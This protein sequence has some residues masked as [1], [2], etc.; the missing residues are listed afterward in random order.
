[1]SCHGALVGRAQG[2]ENP[3]L[4]CDLLFLLGFGRG[5]ERVLGFVLLELGTRRGARIR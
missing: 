5:L 2:R 4:L 3:K 1:M